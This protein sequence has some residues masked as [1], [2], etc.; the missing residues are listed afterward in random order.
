VLHVKA[1]PVAP[2]RRLAKVSETPAAVLDAAALRYGPASVLEDLDGV[3]ARGL[4]V[5]AKPCNIG[6]VR[7]LAEI[8]KRAKALVRYCLTLACG[9]APDLAKS[10]E[11]L[12]HF[13]LQEKNLRLF[14]YRDN[15]TWARLA[16]RRRMA[17]P[18]SSPIRRC[19]ATK[20][21]D[22]TSRAAR[23]AP[24]RSARRLTWSLPAVDPAAHPKARRRALMPCSPERAL[25]YG[26]SRG[27]S[28]KVRSR[29]CAPSDSGTW[30][31]TSPIRCARSAVWA[32]L[33]GMRAAGMAIPQVEGLRSAELAAE[34]D[35]GENEEGMRGAL[36]RAHARRLKEPPAV[37][38]DGASSEGGVRTRDPCGAIVAMIFRR[39]P[40]GRD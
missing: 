27:P 15:G 32:R 1:S 38:R 28:R 22:T 6:A 23:F 31:S 24:I 4:A 37:S 33:E 30:I 25:A 12:D 34:T 5:I 21:A 18:S 13:G 10:L 35:G 20:R 16:W 7:R 11:V 2:L 26:C 39:C 17:A 8:D 14:R 19:G 29:P 3:L 40:G 9:G 36:Q